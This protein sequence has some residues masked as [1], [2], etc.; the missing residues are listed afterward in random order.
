M[1]SLCYEYAFGV[2]HEGLTHNCAFIHTEAAAYP[3]KKLLPLTTYVNLHP[4]L[5]PHFTLL[6]LTPHPVIASLAAET[7]KLLVA[8]TVDKTLTFN[9]NGELVHSRV[10]SL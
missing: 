8:E 9:V 2:F 4:A 3:F 7:G 5:P 10:L 6:L 1:Y